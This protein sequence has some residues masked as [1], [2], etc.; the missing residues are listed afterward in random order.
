MFSDNQ[1][2][3]DW[4]NLMDAADQAEHEPVCRNYPDAFFPNKGSNGLRAELIWAKQTCG[5]CPIRALCAEYGMKWESHGIWGGLT[6]EDR[7]KN[8]AA[9]R[10]PS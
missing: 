4:L 10:R 8:K 3:R 2:N 9:A 5:E 6:A 7:R 1:Q